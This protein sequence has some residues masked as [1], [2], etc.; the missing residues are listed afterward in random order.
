MWTKSTLPILDER[1]LHGS[2]N[3]KRIFADQLINASHQFGC[4]YL[5]QCSISTTLCSQVI[6]KAREFFL[7]QLADK[8]KVHIRLSPHFRGYSEMKNE[9]DW[10]EQV[11]FGLEEPV[12]CQEL[13]DL[14]YRKLQGPNLW[15]SQ[16][17]EDWKDTML[18]FLDAVAS[19]SQ[20]ILSALAWALGLPENYFTVLSDEPPYLLMKLIAYHPQMTKQISHVGVA[21]HCDWSWITF[22]LQDEIGGLQTKLPNGIWADAKPIPNTFFVNLGELLEILTGGYLKATPHHVINQS[23]VRSRISVPIFI[24]PALTARIT[25][26]PI[27]QKYCIRPHNP[28]YVDHEHIHRVSHPFKQVQPFVFGDSEWQRKGQGCWCYEEA[29]YSPNSR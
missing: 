12:A 20:T 22:L 28:S 10:R 14:E 13:S 16:L 17:G 21:P 7:L 2:I 24:N 23:S 4:F 26:V 11:H 18:S 6:S 27:S 15:L 3:Q 1:L 8:S 29:C 5:S 25:P 9:R 19:L